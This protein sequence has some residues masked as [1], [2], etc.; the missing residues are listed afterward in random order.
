[1][2]GSVISS[3][4]FLLF[5]FG[6]VRF[7]FCSFP[8]DMDFLFVID[9]CAFGCA[10]GELDSGASGADGD[11]RCGWDVLFFGSG[12]LWHPHEVSTLSLS[13][14]SLVVYIVTCLL[15]LIGSSLLTSSISFLTVIFPQSSS[16]FAKSIFFFFLAI[17]SICY[18]KGNWIPRNSW[19]NGLQQRKM[20]E[21]KGG[22]NKVEM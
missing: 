14:S 19:P 20:K 17:E 10:G 5:G 11:Q 4:F 12:V 15:S 22:R 18:V 2:Q 6:F 9:M 1:M 13:L 8:S 21:V 16:L 7:F 3:F